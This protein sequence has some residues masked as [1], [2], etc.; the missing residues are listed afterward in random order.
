MKHRLKRI[1]ALE[2][3]LI[4]QAVFELSGFVIRGPLYSVP[5]L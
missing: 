4:N 5:T 1:G 2:N 3:G